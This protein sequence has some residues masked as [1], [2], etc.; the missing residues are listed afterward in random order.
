[1]SVGGVFTLITNDG[2]QDKLI[3]AT[4]LLSERLKLLKEA[5]IAELKKKYPGKTEA[6][7]ADMDFNW[8]P[9]LNMVEKSHVVFVNST[10]KPY[11]SIAHEYSKTLPSTTNPAFG[12]TFHFTLPI[13]GDFVN[14]AV[15][16]VKLTGLTANLA[17]DKV[18][19]VEFPGHRLIKKCSFKMAQSEIDSYTTD[20]Y[21][22]YY[23]FKVPP[24][25]RNGYLRSVGQ[26]IP[27][28]GYLTADPSVDE[29]REYRH[30]GDGP[31]TFKTTQSTLE[32]WIPLLFWFKDIQTSIPNFL[33]PYGQ[34]DI[35]I[36]TAQES[37]MI[38]YANYSGTTNAVYTAP[39]MTCNLY[40]NHIFL[41]PEV[42]DIFQK[43]FGFQLIRVTRTHTD[44]IKKEA[45]SIKLHSMKYP[46]ENMYVAFKPRVNLA[47]S[48]RWHRNTNIT[49]KTV[50]EAV[51]TG[52]ATIQV[53][54]A[55]YLE[56]TP[57][58][59][60]LELRAHDVVLYPKEDVSFYNNYVP[61]RY[62]TFHN[63][64]EDLGWYMFNFAFNPGEYQ[65]SGYFNSSKGREL[66]LL[67]ES[68][69]D[70]NL[71]Q[72]VIRSGNEVDLVVVAECLNFLIIRGGSMALQFCT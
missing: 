19:Y 69:I 35:E 18:R 5:Q 57:V 60:N 56:E 71:Q 16:H 2:I 40:V 31:Q 21:G 52:V 54:S 67:Y 8:Q 6:Q 50:K 38:A 43:R 34:T 51:V 33:L 66:N 12:S 25:K 27:K 36:T 42:R 3:M 11:A 37:E 26:E 39:T 41:I 22:V 65:P 29:V 49:Q 32:M 53:N 30:F 63:T 55:V 17:Q 1:M 20:K 46:I 28:L 45:D 15:L 23:N 44:R 13:Y 10:F 58:V 64:P 61:Y 9:T 24:N 59:Q 14:D 62:G 72:P 4:D 47:N 48:Q 7:L 68:A 70:D